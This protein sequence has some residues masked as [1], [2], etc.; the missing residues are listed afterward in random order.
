MQPFL[1]FV[2]I[3]QIS[4]WDKLSD[5]EVER[6][7][8]A[9]AGWPP[10]HFPSEHPGHKHTS[11]LSNLYNVLFFYCKNYLNFSGGQMQI[12]QTIKQIYLGSHGKLE[13]GCPNIWDSEGPWASRRVKAPPRRIVEAQR[14][15]P[16][17]TTDP[18]R[19]LLAV[20][21]LPLTSSLFPS[22]SCDI[23]RW[24]QTFC[25]L[26]IHWETDGLIFLFQSLIRQ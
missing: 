3:A 19:L 23:C 7:G 12:L 4:C 1:S 17:T 16:V 11:T 22:L 20:I 24:N 26:R 2:N 18:H 14:P 21:C 8:H 13:T 10:S 9:D 15:D 6:I 25:L 5:I